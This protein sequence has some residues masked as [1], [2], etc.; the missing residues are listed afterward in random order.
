MEDY[1]GVTRV[2]GKNPASKAGTESSNTFAFVAIMTMADYFQMFTQF[3]IF[4]SDGGRNNA[5][6]VMTNYIYNV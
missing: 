1:F 6:M 4:V 3:K 2:N 5:A